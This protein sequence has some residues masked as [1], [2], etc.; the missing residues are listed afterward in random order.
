M[1]RHKLGSRLL[2]GLGALALAAPA[3]LAAC[4]PETVAS[5]GESESGESQATESESESESTETETETGEPEPEPEPLG[6]CALAWQ[7]TFTAADG[8]EGFARDL[9][10]DA[11]NNIYVAGG[12]YPSGY[13][14]LAKFDAEGELLWQRE[15]PESPA[16][17]ALALGPEG[18]VH[19]AGTTY[20]P[21]DNPGWV[22]SVDA[23]TGDPLWDQTLE[24]GA[25]GRLEAVT[26]DDDGSVVVGGV[27]TGGSSSYELALARFA[28]PDGTLLWSLLWPGAGD[29]GNDYDD[30]ILSVAVQAGGGLIAGGI[31]SRPSDRAAT[32]FGF[33]ADTDTHSWSHDVFAPADEEYPRVLGVAETSAGAIGVWASASYGK[34]TLLLLEGETRETLWTKSGVALEH[35]IIAFAID[36]EDRL[37]LAQEVDGYAAAVRVW[38]TDAE[39]LCANDE[40]F[41]T[42]EAFV[43][44]WI[45]GSGPTGS[46]AIA[47]V[48]VTSP[49]TRSFHIGRFDPPE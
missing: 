48:S 42:G 7:R 16:L 49:T 13:A 19:A 8:I 14:W 10:L 4:G 6:T 41:T 43:N 26:A 44:N 22:V 20:A 1:V 29:G 11:A 38:S 18:K 46:A 24:L 33:E 9:T 45:G 27:H 28:G 35:T 47:G 21:G 31:D 5:S 12:R 3:L 17:A 32:V 34:N 37:V 36:D 25:Y 40:S 15:F 23:D 39:L 30:R 2:H